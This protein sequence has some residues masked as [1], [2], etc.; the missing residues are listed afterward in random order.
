MNAIEERTTSSSLDKIFLNQDEIKKQH[1]V[2]EA[3]ST[4]DL[5]NPGSAMK[6]LMQNSQ[7]ERDNDYLP[8]RIKLTVAQKATN[9][10]CANTS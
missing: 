4:Q 9:L 6:I 5:F 3:S 7:E 2:I 8:L 10:D 1:E